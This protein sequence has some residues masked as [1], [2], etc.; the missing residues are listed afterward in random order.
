MIK[1]AKGDGA[2]EAASSA[3]PTVPKPTGAFAAWPETTKEPGDSRETKQ[4]ENIFKPHPNVKVQM[5][6]PVKRKLTAVELA[7]GAARG[8]KWAQQTMHQ[9]DEGKAEAVHPGGK[10][11]EVQ[12]GEGE[13]QAW[14]GKEEQQEPREGQHRE[15]RDGEEQQEAPEGQD[16]EQRDGEEQ[17]EP[18]EGQ[19]PEQRDGEEQQEPWEGQHPE[20]RDGEEQPEAPEGQDTEQR[21]GEEQANGAHQE[22]WDQQIWDEEVGEEQ[23]EPWEG[24]HPEQRDGEEHPEAPEGQ[25]P[26]QRD[27]EVEQPQGAHQGWDQQIWAEEGGEEQQEGWH[28]EQGDGDRWEAPGWH[29]KGE[30]EKW[31]DDGWYG[32]GEGEKWGDDGWYGKGEGEGW[33]DDG[34]YGK[35]GGEGWDENELEEKGDNPPEDA[36]EVVSSE[37][38]TDEKSKDEPEE[39]DLPKDVDSLPSFFY[40]KGL[41]QRDDMWNYFTHCV[42]SDHY[43]AAIMEQIKAHKMLKPFEGFIN[44][45]Y[46]MLGWEIHA[47]KEPEE[48]THTISDFVHYLMIQRMT[49]PL[50]LDQIFALKHPEKN[51]EDD[52]AQE[53]WEDEEAQ[54]SWE[55]ENGMEEDTAEQSRDEQHDLGV[56][57]KKKRK[58]YHEMKAGVKKAKTDLEE[59][60]EEK[61]EPGSSKDMVPVRHRKKGPAKVGEGDEAWT[62]TWGPVTKKGVVDFVSNC[63]GQP[64]STWEPNTFK[65]DT[66]NTSGKSIGN[67]N[68]SI[69]WQLIKPGETSYV[70]GRFFCQFERKNMTRSQGCSPQKTCYPHYLCKQD[71]FVLLE[72]WKTFYS[73]RM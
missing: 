16:P 11:E 2:A 35:G 31:G 9:E 12:H 38:K 23:Q 29:G 39:T 27:G 18:W 54:E 26:G 70:L 19:H 32:K 72:I 62:V 67:T 48:F 20:Q 42:D 22:G 36:E 64:V 61:T 21:D 6:K 60:D 28:G 63:S 50:T 44:E 13:V 47:D 71:R 40:G 33:S 24:Q 53:S 41:M 14:G 51:N 57:E 58:E 10:H 8:Y 4:E 17:Q 52:E 49:S 56:K 7:W 59:K 5:V 34:W 65:P 25:D 3:F 30:G 66:I 68:H 69:R 45:T 46:Q 1:N 43:L 15:Q 55:D 73:K 37:T